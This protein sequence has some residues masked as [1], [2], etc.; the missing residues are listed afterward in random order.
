MPKIGEHERCLKPPTSIA[1]IAKMSRQKNAATI[2]QQ[3]PPVCNFWSRATIPEG[4]HAWLGISTLRTLSIYLCVNLLKW[5]WTIH[6][7]FWKAFFP[8]YI[9]IY[10]IFDQELLHCC[11][12][13]LLRLTWKFWRWRARIPL[14]PV[15]AS[16]A[17]DKQWQI[18]DMKQSSVHFVNKDV[19][20][21]THNYV[22]LQ[23]INKP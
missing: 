11:C 7:P 18:Y 20:M 19:P 8:T 14:A 23:P 13:L 4:I 21:S 2:L 16:L 9:Y 5:I 6:D 22:W 3:C 17:M 1:L 12:K 15:S 10:N